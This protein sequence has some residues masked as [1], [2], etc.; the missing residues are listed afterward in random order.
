M[1]ERATSIN[2]HK[3]GKQKRR[4]PKVLGI[5]LG[6]LIIIIAIL[7]A[8]SYPSAVKVARAAKDGQNALL[9]AQ[10]HFEAQDF[11]AATISLNDAIGKFEEADS[12]LRGLAWLRVLPY[13]ARQYTAA[14]HLI[15]AAITS[16]Q[17]I[18]EI[19]DFANT[20]IVPFQNAS[21]QLSLKSLTPQDKRVLLGKLHDADPVLR[22]AETKITQSVEEFN[23]VPKTGLVGPLQSAIDPISEKLPLVQSAVAQFS[24]LART[25]PVLAGYP[26]KQTYLF[27]LQNNTELRPTGGFIGTYG[28]LK[29]DAG[30][31]ETFTTDNIYNLDVPAEKFLDI[32][33][34]EPLQ[35]YLRST[36]WF[37]RDSNWS[38]HFPRAAEQALW[39]YEQE[40][41]PVKSFDGV[42]A[43][44]PSFIESLIELTGSITVQNIEFTRDNFVDTL[45]YQVEQG[46]YQQGI[47]ELARKEIIGEMSQ[48]LMDRLLAL[49]Q[50]DWNRLWSTFLENV[51][52]KQILLY[53]K[54]PELQAIIQDENWGGEVK[55]TED[56]Y[57]YVVD[58]N[59][60]SL[61]SDP[62]V[63]RTISYSVEMVDG[64][65]IATLNVH[66]RN[67]GT[68]TWKSTRYRTY[69]RIYVPLG[70]ELISAEGF[71]TNDKI[72]NGKATEPTLDEDLGKTVIQGFTS[73]E[74]LEEGDLHIQY[75]LP[76]AITDTLKKGDY[77]LD[78]QKQPGTEPHSLEIRIHPGYKS[79]T[80]TPLE[81]LQSEN[82]GVYLSGPL[83][84]DLTF[85]LEK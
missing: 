29:V 14:D 11:S 84:H 79:H 50:S 10:E 67:E 72:Q 5:V 69:T 81:Y 8:F 77:Q 43:V 21:G 27:L 83:S 1:P 26:D 51:E 39:F 31:I 54:D 66:Y 61:K 30:E 68:I 9:N 2:L 46:Y 56:D 22:D 60:A 4:W 62:G 57:L 48:I 80:I 18:H 34:P 3:K 73:I 41:G 32:D 23:K 59:M 28:V 78:V 38:P 19:A 70:S 15:Q 17:A 36:Q 24:S 82:D 47:D 37:L 85:I 25:I 13:A 20:T 7:G 64:E 52:E 40:R 16:S 65:A 35:K 12:A 71:L 44:T 53:L 75:R 63:K 58:A 45:Q 55:E 42:I 6:S 49:P 74:P 33:P 76:K